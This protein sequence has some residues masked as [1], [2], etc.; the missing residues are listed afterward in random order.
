MQCYGTIIF[1]ILSSGY[2][3]THHSRKNWLDRTQK[4]GDL[5]REWIVF[6]NISFNQGKRESKGW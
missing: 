2:G 4:I 1:L 3:L 5:K 6:I